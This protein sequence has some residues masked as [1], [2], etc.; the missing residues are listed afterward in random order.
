MPGWL[1]LF[2]DLNVAVS[3]D[4]LAVSQDPIGELNLSACSNIPLIT[5]TLLVSQASGRLK[6]SA[7]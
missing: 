1:K 2:A 5:S 7:M 3:S 4:T 6:F